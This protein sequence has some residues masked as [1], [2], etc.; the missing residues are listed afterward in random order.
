MKVRTLLGLLVVSALAVGLFWRSANPPDDRPDAR[1]V[2]RE[3][4]VEPGSE[5]PLGIRKPEE[6]PRDGAQPGTASW[7]ARRAHL[8]RS[9]SFTSES[10]LQGQTIDVDGNRLDGVELTL[11]GAS[12]LEVDSGRVQDST[13]SDRDGSFQFRLPDSFGGWL[14]GQAEGYAPTRLR[15][16]SVGPSN[17][18]K[19]VVLTPLANHGDRVEA[20]S[21]NRTGLVAVEN[22]G[23]TFLRGLGTSG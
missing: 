1:P 12:G 11:F 5:A 2:A 16:W 20:D 8:K 21:N 4:S 17:L 19:I 23:Q 18:R 22:S 10:L 9:T 13:V 15:I 7:I 14:R 3:G 6:E